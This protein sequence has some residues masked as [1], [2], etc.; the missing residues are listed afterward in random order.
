MLCILH[1]CYA[2]AP[3]NDNCGGAV[4]LTSST[5]CVN[6]SGTLQNATTAG[7]ASSCGTANSQD[8][9]YTF[10]AQTAYP[11]ITVSSLGASWGTRLR[12]Q[13]FS[14]T[15]VGLTEIACA[16][17]APLNTLTSPGGIGLTPGATYFIRIHKN[18]TTAPTGSGWTFN[19]CITDPTP[20]NIDF[21]KSYVNITKNVG[22]GTI[23]PGDT[24][25]IRA[26]LVIR[27]QSL[28]SL[29]FMD[30]LY[31]NGGVRLIPGSI[32]LRTNE[33]KVY[34]AFTDIL[35]TDAGY[36]YTNGLD[37]VIKINMGTGAT[38]TARGSLSN[39]SKPSVFGSSCIIMATYR[40]VVYANYNSLINVGGGKFNVRDVPTGLT[41][42]LSFVLRNAIIY[43][44]PGLC[45]NAVSATNAIGGDFNGT[46]GTPLTG[47]PLA[48]NRGTSTNVPSYIYKTFSSAGG[49]NDYYYGIANNTSANYTTINTWAKP[50]SKRVFNF[51]DII[52]DHTG[53]TNTAKGN[54]P[55][56][57]TLPVSATNPCGYMLVINSAYKTDTAFQYAVTNL[58][59]NTYYEISAWIRNICYKCSCD[60]NGVAATGGSYIPFATGDSSGV[61]PN[62][63]FDIDGI[64]YFTTGNIVYAGVGATQQGSDSVNIWVKRG[65]TYL[66]GTSQTSLTLSI[67]N[68]APGGGGND[69]ALDDIAFAT[70]LPN[71][72][73]SPTLNPMVCDSNIITIRDTVRS[74]F[75]NYNNYKWQRSTDGGTTWSDIP[76]ASGTAVPYWN[77]SEWEYVASYTVPSNQAY[78]PNNGDKYRLI[79]ATTLSNLANT[80]C[81][82]TDGVS[83]VTLTVLD[84]MG[85]LNTDLLS[86]NGKLVADK[87]SLN[88]TTTNEK[89]QLQYLIERSSNGIN[90]STAGTVAGYNTIG[91]E[92]NNYT[93]KDPLPVTEKVY[94]RLVILN[95][96]NEKKYSRVINMQPLGEKSGLVNVINPF[97]NELVFEFVTTTT[98]HIE[99]EIVDANGKIVRKNNYLLYTGT[100]SLSISKTDLLSSGVYT[101]RINN[102]GKVFTRQI[103]KVN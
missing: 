31:N 98:T 13:L 76:G 58:C 88:W 86:F 15:C 34:K 59:P 2:Q 24:L 100:N 69:W 102:R 7:M 81:Q 84:C 17:N 71:M 57:T 45:P 64:D 21:G 49:P 53:A 97:N 61:Q 94:Y 10:I 33:G 41:R 48:R 28:D 25:E 32:A 65:F 75:N 90:F 23:N 29:E 93:F 12:I 46:F 35:D 43:S 87:A 3:A 26:T 60:S 6:T 37:T 14:G 92:I 91:S 18:N 47:A 78:F 16:S 68:N 20:G 50:D 101:L 1:V 73:Y 52:G 56:D 39:T 44:S 72:K 51:W 36:R 77:G 96:K 40:V 5:S 42:N 79:V 70:C 55:C 4:T 9:W 66:T 85:V 83:I 54:S 22:G 80:S 82:V 19:I 74:Y 103:M 11:V 8:V 95:N 30:T 62:L 89:E 67:R 63:A 99:V 38:S 27:S